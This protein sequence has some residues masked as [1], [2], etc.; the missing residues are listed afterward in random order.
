MAF[1]DFTLWSP[2]RRPR[3]PRRG[4]RPGGWTA[5]RPLQGGPEVGRPALG[6]GPLCLAS[7]GADWGHG[8][9]HGAPTEGAPPVCP[10]T[11]TSWTV[12]AGQQSTSRCFGQSEHRLRSSYESTSGWE[13]PPGP[14]LLQGDRQACTSGPP[15]DITRFV[16]LVPSLSP[17][18][19]SCCPFCL[20]LSVTV[21]C[22]I[23]QNSNRKSSPIPF[24][25]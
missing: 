10:C 7:T 19:I 23:L 17:V 11:R 25:I 8:P 3:L 15:V 1:V 24:P 21:F 5:R 14:W 13:L 9:T 2:D 4:P 18:G 6:G 16:H 12:C 22:G 20:L